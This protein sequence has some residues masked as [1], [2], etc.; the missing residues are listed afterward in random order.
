M[1]GDERLMCFWVEAGALSWK[2]PALC[3]HDIEVHIEQNSTQV[4][5][6]STLSACNFSGDTLM[7]R[8]VALTNLSALGGD[9]VSFKCQEDAVVK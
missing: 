7:D 1:E 3:R 2:L 4:L 8:S 6:Y 9:R 5:I